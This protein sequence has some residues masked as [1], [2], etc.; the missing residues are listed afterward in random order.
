[1]LSGP[2]DL[3]IGLGLNSRRIFVEGILIVIWKVINLHF[4]TP[5]LHV[6]RS[7]AM[8]LWTRQLARAALKP[9]RPCD[10]RNRR[11]RRTALS[12]AT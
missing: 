9:F 12:F 2:R 11:A 7:S 10:M 3:H 6:R 1:M 5:D 4:N 8:V